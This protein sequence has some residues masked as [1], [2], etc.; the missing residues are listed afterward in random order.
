MATF[1]EQLPERFKSQWARHNHGQPSAEHITP[2]VQIDP[3][4]RI[5]MGALAQISKDEATDWLSLPEVPSSL[6]IL[7]DEE[8]IDQQNVERE[9]RRPAEVS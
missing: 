2:P 1:N 5:Y 6:E 3:S 9:Q 8:T 4:I 7:P